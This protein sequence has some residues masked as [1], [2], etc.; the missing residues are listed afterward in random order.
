M[1]LGC[2][3]AAA[4]AQSFF[5]IEAGLGASIA[6]NGP[7]GLWQQEG[8]GPHKKYD[9]PAVEAGITGNLYQAQHWGIDWHIDYA[10]LGQIHLQSPATPSDPN[11]NLAT[12]SCNGA[13]W[14]LADYIGSGHD[15]GVMVTLEP[16]IDYGGWR[17]GVE[18]G[19]W[20]H[21]WSY[22]EWVNN[23][24]SSPTAAPR[25]LYLGSDP[26]WLIGAVVG[27]SVAR[28]PFSLNF[29]YFANKTPGNSKMPV[30]TTGTYLLTVKY[31]A[32]IF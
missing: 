26:Q 1:S 10:W 15:S 5:I 12:K 22:T 28:G 2:A 32:D 3:A 6:R 7:D 29:Q 20:F 24:V 31:T 4:H 14:P 27:A 16:H 8:F 17:F 30:P 11:Y 19:P 25:N 23:W 21:R 18:A 9:A 13:C